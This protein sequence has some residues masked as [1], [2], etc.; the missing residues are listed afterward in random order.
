MQLSAVRQVIDEFEMIAPKDAVLVGVSGGMDS[1]ALLDILLKLVPALS[2]R[3]GVAHL[4]HLLRAGDARRDAE[5]VASLADRLKLPFHQDEADT[6]R[7]SRRQRI[8]IEEAARR[9]RYD[10][11]ASARARHGYNKVAV[12]HHADDNA[13]LILMQLIRGGGLASLAGIPPVREDKIIRPLIRLTRQQILDYCQAAGL[14]YVTDKTNFDRRHV[15][16]RIRHDLMPLL[17]K[18]YNPSVMQSLNRL[19]EIVRD[20]LQWTEDLEQQY[21]RS[22]V[23]SEDAGRLGL[24]LS[25]LRSLHPALRRRVLRKAIV[26]VKSDLRRVTF[27]H[28]ETLSRQIVAEG[29]DGACVHLPDRVVAHITDGELIVS[30]SDTDLRKLSRPK[31][32]KAQFRYSVRAPLAEP[33]TIT[34]KEAGIRVIFNIFATDSPGDLRGAGQQQAFFDMEKLHFPLVMRGLQPGDRFSPLGAGGT[35]KVKKF[36]IDHKVP[37]RQRTRCPLLVSENKIVWVVGH[38]IAEDAKVTASTT[39]VLRAEVQVV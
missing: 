20:E 13:E 27:Q 16:N 38:R 26:L 35:Q 19:S 22:A 2:I 34:L 18:Q 7:C 30:K 11:F 25:A 15:R 14:S 24:S 33:V 32:T 37:R 8:S 28:I 12:G 23:N 10:F 17:Q 21:F 4:N 6:R 39:V 3:V 1:V 5:F 31:V 36:L 29:T 9:L